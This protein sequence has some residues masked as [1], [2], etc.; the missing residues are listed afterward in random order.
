MPRPSESY[1]IQELKDIP[2]LLKSYGSE[3]EETLQ[4]IQ[5]KMQG[6]IIILCGMW[7]SYFLAE[8]GAHFIRHISRADKVHSCESDELI[9][10]VPGLSNKYAL[11]A[12]SQSGNTKETVHAIELAKERWCFTAVFHNQDESNC[13]KISDVPISQN[14]GTEKSP[15]STK[16]IAFQILLLYRLG[17]LLGGRPAWRTPDFSEINTVSDALVSLFEKYES[18][19]QSLASLFNWERFVVVWNGL[20]LYSAQEIALK[21][22]ETTWLDASYDTEWILNHGGINSFNPNTYCLLLNSPESMKDKTREKGCKIMTI[23]WSPTDD[24][25]IPQ[26]NR[27]LDTCLTIALGQLLPT[28]S[29]VILI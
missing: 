13:H 22:R 28:I 6:K 19:I 26:T 5:D 8:I 15:V 2:F 24:I 7:S 29:L 27:Y 9:N 3:H 17:V 21:I 10:Q 25:I 14:I 12:L 23:W 20:N 18:K 1:M 4:E 11:I 16:Y